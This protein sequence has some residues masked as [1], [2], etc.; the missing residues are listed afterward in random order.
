MESSRLFFEDEQVFIGRDQGAAIAVEK[1]FVRAEPE[2][3]EEAVTSFA[4]V[5]KQLVCAACLSDVSLHSLVD[6]A[7]HKLEN[8]DEIGFS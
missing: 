7:V 1:R 4:A 6:E 3:Y 2:F 8:A 5:V